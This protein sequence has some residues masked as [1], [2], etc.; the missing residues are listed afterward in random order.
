MLHYKGGGWLPGVPSRDLSDEEATKFGERVL[1]KSGLY[2]KVESEID[3]Q[4]AEK[5]GAK[6]GS[7]NQEAS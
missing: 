3:P 4:E 1:I 6:H 7:R 2:E 5:K